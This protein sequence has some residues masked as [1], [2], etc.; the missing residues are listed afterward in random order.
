MNR[1]AFYPH[2]LLVCNSHQN[3]IHSL[4]VAQS[5]VLAWSGPNIYAYI[6]CW[7]D[8][9]NATHVRTL[10]VVGLWFTRK[11]ISGHPNNN[12]HL[13]LRPFVRRTKTLPRG[14]AATAS[15]SRVHV[16]CRRIYVLWYISIISRTRT[17]LVVILL[18]NQP[19]RSGI[20]GGTRDG[21][22]LEEAR[23]RRKREIARPSPDTDRPGRD[24]LGS[25]STPPH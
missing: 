17:Y 13:H 20:L 3:N 16:L 1:T 4:F 25:C 21:I 14:D 22:L 19:H 12:H 10:K 18:L 6:N 8:S 5:L 24:L 23:R 2:T 7:A 15:G 9:G 11:T